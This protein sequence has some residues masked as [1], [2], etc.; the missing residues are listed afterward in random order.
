MMR[1]R[2]VLFSLAAVIIVA[3]IVLRLAD[4][5]LVDLL[6]FGVLGYRS[7]FTDSPRRRNSR[8]SR[9]SGSSPSSPYALSGFVALRL[10]PASA[11]GSVSCAAPKRWPRSIC[12]S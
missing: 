7:V 4:E 8:F 5:L 2:I 3:L 9:R 10:Q 11:S 12:P 6:W 1:P